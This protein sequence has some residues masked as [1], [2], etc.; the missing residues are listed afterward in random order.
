MKYLACA[1]ACVSFLVAADVSAETRLEERCMVHGA[2]RFA[3]VV[4]SQGGHDVLIRDGVR[5]RR[6]PVPGSLSS[7]LQMGSDH[8]VVLVQ[9][10][11]S[12]TAD[13]GREL[14]S[15]SAGP[16]KWVR[17]MGLDGVRLSF[18]GPYGARLAETG[19]W[20]AV[21]LADSAHAPDFGSGSTVL[22]A[23]P[24]RPFAVFDLHG[25]KVRAL[26]GR[27]VF[28]QYPEDE[29]D[30][31]AFS[32]DGRAIVMYRAERRAFNIYGLDG[33][34]PDETVLLPEV[35]ENFAAREFAFV[36]DGL[37]VMWQHEMFGRETTDW[38]RVLSR[39]PSGK[40]LSRSIDHEDRYIDMR[41]FSPD[42]RMLLSGEH[43][44]DVVDTSG[45]LI[46]RMNYRGWSD[47]LERMP[48][49]DLRKWQPSLLPGGDVVLRNF[50]RG[51][52][53]HPLE[54]VVVQLS[55]LDADGRLDQGR[56]ERL[57][58]RADDRPLARVSSI[59]EVPPAAV[60]GAGG[61][62]MLLDPADGTHPVEHSDRER[63]F[64]Y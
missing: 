60:I 30:D 31:Y 14:R 59:A 64:E 17:L 8:S 5:A 44:F 46:W 38:L 52:Q 21:E 12:E 41:R 62:H 53:P 40:W 20:L 13:K 34:T 25:R 32:G 3:C 33:S 23:A 15:G 2:D 16:T 48:V 27:R 57:V 45:R 49:K 39:D 42:G 1:T 55:G 43:G 26:P 63:P 11:L 51:S 56:A 47:L 58:V 61:R 35:S 22:R 29:D 54:S 18:D 19:D 9:G 7:P 10:V 36:R 6:E 28:M 50:G 37:I 24:A 4:E